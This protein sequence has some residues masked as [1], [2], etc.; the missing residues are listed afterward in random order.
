[1]TVGVNIKW[2]LE[3]VPSDCW[4]NYQMGIIVGAK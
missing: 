3:L 1:M 4:S 2:V